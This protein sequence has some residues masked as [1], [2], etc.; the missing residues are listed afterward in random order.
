ALSEARRRLLD[1]G[2]LLPFS[3]SG[4]RYSDFSESTA[5]AAER[6]EV[7]TNWFLYFLFPRQ[8]SD[9]TR[10]LWLTYDA[11]LVAL[12]PAAAEPAAEHSHDDDYDEYDDEWVS[13]PDEYELVLNGDLDAL[14]R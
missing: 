9:K 1:S 14:W 10:P 4:G 5:G 7:G 8:Y 3:E 13:E 6:A 11:R 12:E 2:L